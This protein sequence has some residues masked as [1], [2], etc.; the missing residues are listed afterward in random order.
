MALSDVTCPHCGRN[1]FADAEGAIEV[2]CSGCGTSVQVPTVKTPATLP[3]TDRSTKRR[4]KKSFAVR[5]TTRRG[6]KAWKVGD[7][8]LDLYD[9]TA[10]L[11]RGGMGDV[12]R[13]RH[14]GWGID[15]A[16]KTPRAEI[17]DDDEGR[18]A[19]VREAETWAELGVHP[20]VV[21][22]HYVRTIGGIPRIFAEFVEG[23]SLL[24]WIRNRKLADTAQN[25]N[26][27][28]QFAWGL[29]RAHEIGVIHQDVKPANVMM[30]PDGV[31][32]VTDF[33]LSKAKGRVPVAPGVAGDTA[34][35]SVSGFT[36]AYCSPEQWERRPLTRRTDLW[37]WAVSVLEMF[38]GQTLWANGV[39]AP[40]SMGRVEMPGKLREFLA[41][42]FALDPEK[43]PA[44]MRDAAEA[45]RAIHGSF[46]RPEPK[47]SRALADGLNNRA[48]SMLDLGRQSES[49][50]LFDEA[51]AA[52]PQHAV[53]IYNRGLLDWRA[54]RLTD[55][56]LIRRLR[57]RPDLVAHVEAERGEVREGAKVAGHRGAITSVAVARG[58]IVTGG[59][60]RSV[61]LWP[62]G[63]A[64][65]G[66]TDGVNAVAVTPDGWL[67]LSASVDRTI[68]AWNV[69]TRKSLKVLEGHTGPVSGVAGSAD[70]KRA[71]SSSWDGSL[72][73]WEVS[74]GKC[75]KTLR[76]HLEGVNAL[77]A[78]PDFLLAVSAGSDGTARVWNLETGRCVATLS[79]HKGAVLAAS[80]APDGRR[81]LTG[82]ADHVVRAWDLAT[83]ECLEVCEGHGDRVLALATDGS[84]AVSGGRDRTVRVWDG[85]RCVR[86]IETADAVL[87]VA[88]DGRILAAGDGL[89]AF[90]RLAPSRSP[91]IIVRP[92]RSEQISEEEQR[93]SQTLEKVRVAIGRKNWK[94]AAMLL[95]Q[96]RAVAGYERAP[97]ALELWAEVSRWTGR[98]V[99]RD[100][101]QRSVAPGKADR[102]AANWNGTLVATASGRQVKVCDASGACGR[103]FE[104]AVVSLAMSWDGGTVFG[105]GADGSVRAWNAD[106]ERRF[107][108][109]HVGAVLA[110]AVSADGR[111]VLTGGADGKLRLWHGA[112]GRVTR[113]IDAH[114]RPVTGVA[115]SA[116]ASFAVSVSEDGTLKLWTLGDGRCLRVLEGHAGAV[117]DVA[118]SE[119]LRTVT[120]VGRDRTIREWHLDWNLSALDP[121]MWH[122]GARPWLEA[123][124]TCGMGQEELLKRLQGGGYGW[125]RPEGVALKLSEI[126]PPRAP[127]K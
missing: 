7:T 32:K 4:A 122:E 100:A 96:A 125:L 44:T 46:T 71:L 97:E 22:C 11:G 69:S 52:D 27:A 112:S 107:A 37:S 47:S 95:A 55:D 86:T 70:G 21:T 116:D 66:H 113:A 19:F 1:W 118:L 56:A 124:L 36:P 58:L 23:G 90:E 93:V 41:A 92:R 54:G 78:T 81:A 108:E 73:L 104:G 40:R 64:L 62:S 65:E 10:L 38:A 12:F 79:G 75:V 94:Q 16:V 106:G 20:H 28:I 127:R 85:A 60:D 6:P 105:G 77:S 76:E 31:A 83:M 14:R 67:V 5:D 109:G 50:R 103:T 13:V 99:L 57:E 74:T 48:L 35:V 84:I 91:L 34:M 114:A 121:A 9:V 25:L 68:R 119:D 101:W 110:I 53:A 98:G 126:V 3:G 18:D 51:L 72:K 117:L 61:R 8:I 80:V 111:Q 29:Q 17:L 33:G 43:R 87:A 82:G 102:I 120:T 42:C 45:L 89:R 24:E 115:M 26:I 39:E 2:T 15:L 49:V 63:A 59:R 30:T 88:L 123:A